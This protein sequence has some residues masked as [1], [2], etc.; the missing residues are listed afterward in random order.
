[1][2]SSMKYTCIACRLSFSDGDGQ[3][4]HYRGDWHRYN[5]KRKAAGL[6]CVTQ[7]AF[8]KRQDTAR[9]TEG[10]GTQ[11]ELASECAVCRKR[12]LS[13]N[14]YQ[15]H[16]LSKKHKEAEQAAQ[17][18]AP[19]EVAKKE[20]KSAKEAA[21][22][23]SPEE[24]ERQ[25]VLRRA[26]TTR[27]TSSFEGEMTTEQREELDALIRDKDFIGKNDC[28]FCGAS[29]SD[30]ESNMLHMTKTHGFFIPDLE[31]NV[32]LE[33]FVEYLGQKISLANICLYCDGKG[34]SF[35]SREA[36]QHHMVDKSHCK[37]SYR[38][39]E[40]EFEPFYDYTASYPSG[41]ITVS[42]SLF[43]ADSGEL[44]LPSRKSLGHRSLFRYYKQKFAPEEQ[45]P[46]VLI[47]RLLAEYRLLGWN[48]TPSAARAARESRDA[49]NVA[50][51]KLG[52]MRTRVGMQFN[53]PF[54][55]RAQML[56]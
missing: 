46:S 16:M 1:M 11:K 2:A 55:F 9:T 12:Y 10:D 4:E 41:D 26:F 33:G 34:R 21:P 53:K 22:A 40:E 14:A 20:P 47:N 31:Y 50:W 35:H 8:A 24:Q 28:L 18:E 5:L 25:D 32:N 51:R 17:G 37:I 45:R 36:V 52:E 3:K 15:Q 27:Y 23:L 13:K 6:P 19:E 42:E 43:V 39:D 56:V 7:E 44:V 49:T 38:G 54:H 48:G 30:F 29:A